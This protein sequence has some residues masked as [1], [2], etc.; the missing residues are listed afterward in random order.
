MR[1]NCR[2]ESSPRTQDPGCFPGSLGVPSTLKKFKLKIVSEE[3]GGD[4]CK[5]MG[6]SP[7]RQ[8]GPEETKNALAP[9]QKMGQ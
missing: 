7:P 8:A 2:N 6:F 1:E 4:L 3:L 9:S 5:T